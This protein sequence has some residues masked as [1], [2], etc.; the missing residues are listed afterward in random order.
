MVAHKQTQCAYYDKV[1]QKKNVKNDKIHSSFNSTIK[2]NGARALQRKQNFQM[3]KVN[4]YCGNLFA[5]QFFT[6]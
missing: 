1:K 3:A 6:Q 5:A 4:F 2:N